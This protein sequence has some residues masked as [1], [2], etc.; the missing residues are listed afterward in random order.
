GASIYAVD[1][2][3]NAFTFSFPAVDDAT[4]Y[5]IEYYLSSAE[6]PVW[7]NLT[8]VTYTTDDDGIVTA[9]H[10]N[11]SSYADYQFRVRSV[12]DSGWSE[13]NAVEVHAPEELAIASYDPE[14]SSLTLTWRDQNNETGYAL[15]GI[16]V[17]PDGNATEI[18]T[19]EIDA[20]E[21]RYVFE[22]V[23]PGYAYD[24]VLTATGGSADAFS[25]I[26]FAPAYATLKSPYYAVGST[27]SA[28]L[29]PDVAEATYS[30]RASND[31]EEWFT[32]EDA[33]SATLAIDAVLAEY[34]QIKV[35]ATGTGVSQGSSSEVV[36]SPGVVA[37]DYVPET[38]SATLAWSAVD[39]AVR[40]DALFSL[41]G[42]ATWNDSITSVDEPTC[43]VGE[44][45]AGQSYFFV[46]YAHD[47]DEL[48]IGGFSGTFAPVSV[49]ANVDDYRVGDSVSV[50]VTASDDASYEIAWFY[51]TDDGDV[52]IEEAAGLLEYVPATADYPIKVVVTGTGNSSGSVSETTVPVHT[53][54][55]GAG[56]FAPY[57]TLERSVALTWNVVDGATCY[58]FMEGTPNDDDSI[59]WQNVATITL[60]DGVVTSGAAT[61]SDDLMELTYT[62]GSLNAGCNGYYKVVAFDALDMALEE[63][64]FAYASFGLVLD[65]D[66][67]SLEGDA[68]VASTTPETNVSYQWSRSDDCGETWTA[69]ENANDPTWSIPSEDAAYGRWLKLVATNDATGAQAVVYARPR[70]LEDAPLDMIV[71][72]DT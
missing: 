1:S 34:R 70:T 14:T 63:Q 52:A 5:Q 59:A 29:S 33:T 60:E 37:F 28:S 40:Y 55:L 56:V 62:I 38:R 72:V 12:N 32:I 43:V 7:I 65:H 44:L 4:G 19:I 9:S 57:D 69:L 35:V 11:A 3:A 45:D 23:L 26:S 54:L 53:N 68:L 49:V 64:E 21:T 16:V 58:R 41:D 30:W 22:G 61:L 15:S 67:Y 50:T 51:A 71:D 24:F 20:N 31:G 17:D 10:V 25:E 48:R 2:D 42:G 47:A 8:N 39:S 36:A 6:Y 66:A 18:A 13:W 27:L 46:V